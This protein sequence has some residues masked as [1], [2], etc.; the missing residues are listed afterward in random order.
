VLVL[1]MVT[2]IYSLF[3]LYIKKCKLFWK[4][5]VYILV[6]L[7]YFIYLSKILVNF[8]PLVVGWLEQSAGADRVTGSSPVR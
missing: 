4:K 2:Y 8:L 3:Y 6:Q 7:I 1:V 5:I